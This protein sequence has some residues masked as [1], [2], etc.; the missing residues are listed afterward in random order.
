[1]VRS[2]LPSAA[3]TRNRTPAHC[4]PS[5][6]ATPVSGLTVRE[7]DILQRLSALS[8]NEEIA[9]DLFLSPNT[10]KT[11]LKSLYRKLEVTRDPMR[12]D[13][14]GHSVCAEPPDR[15]S[16]DVPGADAGRQSVP[17]AG[18]GGRPRSRLR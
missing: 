10:V 1:M 17:P 5:P 15:S 11:H 8:T 16:S 3:A 4:R 12:S 9:A 7:I 13:G 14:A 2:W 18:S 6:V